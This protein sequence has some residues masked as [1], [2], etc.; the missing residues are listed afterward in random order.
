MLFT[1]SLFL[2]ARK[3]SF[4]S[5]SHKQIQ[6]HSFFSCFEQTQL[7]MVS[8]L[9]ISCFD[10]GLVHS[11]KIKQEWCEGFDFDWAVPISQTLFHVFTVRKRLR[12]RLFLVLFHSFRMKL[13]CSYHSTCMKWV[14]FWIFFIIWFRHALKSQFQRE[15]FL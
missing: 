9:W 8:F 13:K 5:H 2:N 10:I 11:D 7:E 3:H 14:R 6:L 15:M 12:G 4:S 1:E